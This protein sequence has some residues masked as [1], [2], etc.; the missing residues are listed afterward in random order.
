[1]QH[2]MLLMW[3][4]AVEYLNNNNNTNINCKCKRSVYT[5]DLYRFKSVCGVHCVVAITYT[6]IEKDVLVSTLFYY[7]IA[8]QCTMWSLSK[9][10]LQLRFVRSFFISIRRVVF[11][12]TGFFFSLL[13]NSYVHIIIFELK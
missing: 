10:A 9:R 11:F 3:V 8:V 7:T 4:L 13:M 6:V 1:M 12:F 2:T 5:V